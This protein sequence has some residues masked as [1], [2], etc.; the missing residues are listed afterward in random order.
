[1]PRV[2]VFP[3]FVDKARCEHVIALATKMLNP[4]GLAYRP[5]EKFDPAQQTRTSQGTFLSAL[6]VGCGTGGLW[7]GC[8]L[9]RA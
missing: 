3:G 9:E 6:Q 7:D 8:G 5:G 1:M 2:V 4:S